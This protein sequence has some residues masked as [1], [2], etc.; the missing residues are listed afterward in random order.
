MENSKPHTINLKEF[1]DYLST[2]SVV[3]TRNIKLKKEIR[4]YLNGGIK[5]FHEGVIVWQGIQ[6]Y[7]AV[8]VY[9]SIK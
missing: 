6:P 9:N 4:V 5:I 7:N 8:E 3:Y 2:Y 1:S